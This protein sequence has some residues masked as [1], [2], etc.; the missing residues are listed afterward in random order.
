MSPLVEES[1][2]TALEFAA[3]PTGWG[4]LLALAALVAIWLLVFW[5]YRR[6]ARRGAG[7]RLRVALAVLRCVVLTLVALVLLR[8]VLATYVEHTTA[9]QL[10][11]LADA[12]AS[13]DV[14]DA[15]APAPTRRARVQTLLAE[16]DGAWLRRLAERNAVRLYD[17]A[18]D[19]VERPTSPD[20]PAPSPPDPSR[21]DLGRA[22]TATLAAAGAAPLAGV[23]LLTDGV[24]NQGMTTAELGA[25]AQRQRLS[26]HVIGVGAVDE[27]PN[28]RLSP[29]Q[30]PGVVPRGDPFELAVE[31]TA[32]GVDLDGELTLSVTP[33]AGGDERV[34]A[35]RPV[36]QRAADPPQPARFPVDPP[37]A[38]DYRYRVSIAPV[39]GEVYTGDNTREA[40]VR[41][42]DTQL[43]VL[44]V[45]AWPSYEYRYL[46]RLL[47]RDATIAVSCWLQSAHPQ[48]IRDGDEPLAALP[49]V[50]ES[51]FAYDVVVLHDPDPAALPSGWGLL[52]RRFVDELGGGLLL[53]AG[54][55]H[56]TRLLRDPQLADLATL[57]PATVDADAEVRLRSAGAFRTTSRALAV[58]PT[59]R[60][61]AE[62]ALAPDAAI[63]AQIWAALPGVWWTLPLGR[64]KP[65]GAPLL[66]L[67]DGDAQRDA[68]LV[69]QPFGAGR[70][71]LLATDGTW[72]W[73]S[74]AEDVHARFWV[75]LIRHL[76]EARRQGGHPRGRLVLDRD[77][78]APGE[79]L[80]VEAR[81]LDERYA[82]WPAPQIAT[83]V[84]LGAQEQALV[85][86]AAPDRPGWFSGRLLVAASGAG[87][88]RLAIPGPPADDAPATLSARFRSELPELE[89]RR[90]A[91]PVDELRALAAQ[92]GGT[93]LP[94]EEAGRLPDLIPSAAHTR[95]ERE[96]P[97]DLWDRPW[98]LALLVGLLAVE[99]AVRRRYWLL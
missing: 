71:A 47:E 93:Y 49:D 48:A 1:R 83:T 11:V 25:Y 97:R 53:Q 58:P 57:L 50:P 20:G 12:S 32:T 62:V 27:P 7:P 6:E 81:L 68:V 84:T 75:Q 9:A 4:R 99:W 91:Q 82:A 8:P 40:V 61:H 73:R 63:S 18:A 72:R 77:T 30:A 31:V 92:T 70:V 64:L 34:L 10:F 76:A 29:L 69:T 43:R 89:L 3:L 35:T 95:V 36:R 5:L 16:D 56:T 66:A 74:T 94:L 45:A 85:L 60:G 87:E 15:A 14:A 26:L 17:F 23:V 59:A 33:L 65:L 98:V 41:V 2:R 21:T 78:V 28:V 22:V 52:V 80:H 39:R 86:P 44:I 67:A 88:V 90:L 19:A 37:E 79:F 24:A 42:F 55:Q 54:P 13:M 96:P 51:L 38:G 46:T